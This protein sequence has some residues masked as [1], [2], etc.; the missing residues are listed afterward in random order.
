MIAPSRNYAS[1]IPEFNFGMLVLAQTG[2]Y[3][4]FQFHGFYTSIRWDKLYLKPR[5]DGGSEAF[6]PRH[7]ALHFILLGIGGICAVAVF[8]KEIVQGRRVSVVDHFP[9]M[10][11]F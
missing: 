8:A 1:W 5:F 4:S 7:V 11:H 6:G 2:I 3:D 10:Q 9:K